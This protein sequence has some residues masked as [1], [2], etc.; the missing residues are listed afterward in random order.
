MKMAKSKN[1]INEI[2]FEN[3]DGE[4]HVCIIE[5][6]RGVYNV[7]KKF[8]AKASHKANVGG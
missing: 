2:S 3:V 8:S 6:A 4:Y 7:L 5:T 1:Q